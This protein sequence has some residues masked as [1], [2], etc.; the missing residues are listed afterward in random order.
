MK[1]RREMKGVEI[2]TKRRKFTN[3]KGEQERRKI[4]F[5]RKKN[6]SEGKCLKNSKKIIEK[7]VKKLH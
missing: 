4:K 7:D 1:K 5:S 2:N 6:I 3:E